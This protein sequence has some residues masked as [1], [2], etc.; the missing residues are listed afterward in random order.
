MNKIGHVLLCAPN[1]ITVAIE[2]LK[3]F[4]EHK[5]NLQVGR[6][7]QIAQ[8]NN[9]Y[10][11]AVIR[12]VRGNTSTNEAGAI[13]WQFIVSCQA[14]GNLTA[15]QLFERGAVLLPVPTEPAYIPD[16]ATLDKLFAESA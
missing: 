8:G 1:E 9:D 16:Q 5:A 11:V 4:E 10:T 3:A 2:S 13:E 6:Y 12:N 15:A 14:V 7:L